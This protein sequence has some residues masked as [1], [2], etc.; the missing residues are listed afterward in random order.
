MKPISGTK[1]DLLQAPKHAVF[2]FLSTF[3]RVEIGL[4]LIEHFNLHFIT[5]RRPLGH[6]GLRVK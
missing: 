3:M 4:L 5:I 1:L 2:C 6:L